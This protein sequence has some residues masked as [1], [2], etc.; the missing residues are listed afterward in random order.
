MRLSL[1]RRILIQQVT[2][3]HSK[4]WYLAGR[5]VVDPLVIQR[6][7]PMCKYIPEGN[8]QGALR[9]SSEQLRAKLSNLPKRV[10]SNLQLPLH[11]RLAE[12]I[13]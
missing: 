1:A 6:G 13:V 9:N 10:S 11:R 5:R 3:S 7:V 8:N 4:R 2:D 12:L